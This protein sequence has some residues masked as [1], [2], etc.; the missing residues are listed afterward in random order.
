MRI[1]DRFIFWVER[2]NTAVGKA[3]S[4]L[5]IPMGGAFVIEVFCRKF[6]EPTIWAS[7]FA[8]MMYGTHFFLGCAFT[9]AMNKHI[10]TDFLYDNWSPKTRAILDAVQYFLFFLPGLAIYL[11]VSIE[12]AADSWYFLESMA[13]TWR[14]PAYL[15]KTVVPV[16]VFLLLLQ[17]I[18]ELI[19]CVRIIKGEAK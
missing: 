9:L 7:D 17:G 10:R 4:W 8:T 15:Y 19:K 18:V 1:L 14:P 6:W 3:A 12:F 16:S 5:I 13:T 11:Y 2:I